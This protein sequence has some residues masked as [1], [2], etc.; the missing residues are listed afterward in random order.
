[1]QHE[2]LFSLTLDCI[3]DLCVTTSPERRYDNRL[4]L[5][6]CKK[7][8]SVCARQKANA[9]VDRPNRCLVAP[10]DSRLAF[11][12]ALTNDGLFQLRKSA[13]DLFR[14]PARLFAA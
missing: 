5:T 6:A 8:R 1:V 10:V 3:D 2:G 4:R 7:R 9:D 11:D 14:R 12:N 13:L